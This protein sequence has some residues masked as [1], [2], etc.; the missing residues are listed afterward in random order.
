MMISSFRVKLLT[1]K[2]TNT[3]EVVKQQSTATDCFMPHRV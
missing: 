1:D 3:A 2:Q